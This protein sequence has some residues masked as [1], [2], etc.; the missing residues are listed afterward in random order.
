MVEKIYG[1]RRNLERLCRINLGLKSKGNLSMSICKTASTKQFSCITHISM[2]IKV[3]TFKATDTRALSFLIH[4]AKRSLS[5]SSDV[6]TECFNVKSTVVN[7][8]KYH[9]IQL[10]FCLSIA[11]LQYRFKIIKRNEN[12]VWES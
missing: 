3:Q 12:L 4:S 6:N 9:S 10:F 7:K 1:K 2:I 11:F 8:R 5:S